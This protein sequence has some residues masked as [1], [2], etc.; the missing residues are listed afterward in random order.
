[1]LTKVLR[2]RMALSKVSMASLRL[3]ICLQKILRVSPMKL[4]LGMKV[5][6]TKTPIS[7]IGVFV[8]NP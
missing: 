7:T 5:Y 1:M 3:S 2:R 4:K 6:S 8:K